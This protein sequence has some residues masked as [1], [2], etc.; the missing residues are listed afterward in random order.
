LVLLYWSLLIDEEMHACNKNLRE[1]DLR[2][3][4]EATI[5]ALVRG[6]RSYPSPGADFVIHAN[7]IVVLTAAH[8]NLERAFLFL[9]KG[10]F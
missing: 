6:G 10:E 7:D 9:E 8:Q 2:K 5:V 4:T 3:I 1:L